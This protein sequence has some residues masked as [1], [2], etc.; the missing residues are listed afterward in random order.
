MPDPP[1]LF[2]DTGW[3]KVPVQFLALAVVAR[4]GGKRFREICVLA[5]ASEGRTIWIVDAHRDE[6]KRYIY[7]REKLRL[8]LAFL[9]LKQREIFAVALFLQFLHRNKTKRG[10]VHTEPLTGRGRAV[11]KDVAEMRIA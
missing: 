9:R 8:I 7:G 11:I 10:G 3:V 6:G 2:I 1:C 5:V 4:A